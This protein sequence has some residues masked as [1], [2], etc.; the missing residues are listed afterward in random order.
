[1]VYR[2]LPVLRDGETAWK[3][4]HGIWLFFGTKLSGLDGFDHE[5]TIVSS[6]YL[7]NGYQRTVR[8]LS[9][10]HRLRPYALSSY[11][12]ATVEK[13]LSFKLIIL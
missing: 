1:M 8:N 9:N 2:R 5:M 13:I 12:L 10:A 6:L 7:N 11:L 3:A 4:K